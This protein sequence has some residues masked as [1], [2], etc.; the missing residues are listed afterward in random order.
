MGRAVCHVSYCHDGGGEDTSPYYTWLQSLHDRCADGDGGMSRFDETH[1]AIFIVSDNMI[2]VRKIERQLMDTGGMACRLYSFMS[3]KEAVAR[4]A[5]PGGRPAVIIFDT[6][7]RNT[8]DPRAA[9]D[10]L[11]ENAPGVPYII[12][13]GETTEEAD[14]TAL[15]L[16]EGAHGSVMRDQIVTLPGML[17]DLVFGTDRS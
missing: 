5:T 6:R 12:L 2:D 7:L 16:S 3:V 13:A 11:K 15:L 17:R 10:A 8:P 14:V 4:A 9:L 1:K